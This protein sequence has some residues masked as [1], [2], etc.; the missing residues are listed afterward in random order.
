M[1][2][3]EPFIMFFV[4][5]MMSIAISTLKGS[6]VSV[7]LYLFVGWLMSYLR[8]LCLFGHNVSKTYCVVLFVLCLSSS[9]VPGVVNFSGLYI[10]DCLFGFLWIVHS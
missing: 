4:R 9:C 5:I 7:C 10:I 2:P 8:Y 1:F 3:C 6:S